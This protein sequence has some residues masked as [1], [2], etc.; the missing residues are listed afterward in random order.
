MLP[1]LDPQAPSLADVLRSC[2]DSLRGEANR[3]ALPT[4]DSAIVLLVDGLG[5]EALRASAG[6][7]RTLA[8]A[9]GKR[10]TIASG[11]P[12]TTASA[13]ASLTTGLP[14][15]Q[16]GLVGYSVLDADH[17]RVVNQ[18][19]GWDERLDPLRW[20][21]FP[22]LF[23]TASHLGFAPA[24][25]GPA[26]FADSGFTRA[27]LRGANYLGARSI[28][29]RLELAAELARTPGSL[30]YAYVPELDQA[31]HAHGWKSQQWT[32]ALEEVDSAIR[33]IVQS[34]PGRAGLIVTADHG[35]IDIPAHAHVVID[36]ASELL[37][38]VRFVA[39]EPRGLQLHLEDPGDASALAAAWRAVE[40]DRAWIATRDEA[41]AATWF[42]PV[43][44]DVVPRIGDVLVAAR[45]NVAY[46]LSGSPG[47]NMVGQHGSWSSA[48][49]RVP[50]VRFGAYAR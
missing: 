3:L 4:V 16:H 17:D 21:P 23:E 50:L 20:Q 27:V 6:H 36:E 11:F 42:G 34:L 32:R 9:M 18:L 41:I 19:T 49:L 25:I 22:T 29:D 48:E 13:L 8:S 47:M 12:T 15:G 46:Y 45:K 26:K 7:A 2:L 33:G 28:A 14:P 39:G 10:D 5:A 44:A 31:G 24:A 35:M 40:G 37:A 1:A 43:R 38:G 30:V